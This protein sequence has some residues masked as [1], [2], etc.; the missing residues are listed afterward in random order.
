MAPLPLQKQILYGMG[1]V[2]ITLSDLLIMQWLLVRYL[3][4]DRPHL[5]PAGLMGALLLLSRFI[6]GLSFALVGNWSDHL[7]TRWGRRMPFLRLTIVPFALLFFLMFNPPMDHDHWI[8][9]VYVSIV[10][11]LYFASYGAIVVP[12]LA[13]LP[14]LTTDLRAR[15]NLITWQSIFV[16]VA[17]FMFAATGKLLSHLGW[18]LVMGGAGV[19]STLFFVPVCSFR[20]SPA[21]DRPG[22]EPLSLW[23]S[24]R[25]AL[26][27][28]A[29]VYA[30][31]PMGI[32]W[33]AL[34]GLTALVPF[35]VV[36]CLG[37]SRDDV[38][39]V[40]VLYLLVSLVAYFGVN[41]LTARI[42]KYPVLCASYLF[43]AFVLASFSLVGVVPIGSDFAQTMVILAACGVPVAGFTV[44]AFPLLADVVDH[45]ER[46]TGRRREAIFYG[47]KGVFQKVLIGFSI[48]TF[49]VV[50][51]L[52]STGARQLRDDGWV[53]FSG[54]YTG[55]E[56]PAPAAP[57]PA[58]PQ[59]ARS[60]KIEVRPAG[61]PAPWY[62]KGPGGSLIQ[63][64]GEKVLTDL[65]AG[66]YALEWGEV[67]GWI[68]PPK[69]KVPTPLGLKIMGVVCGLASF[70]AFLVFRKYPLRERGGSVVVVGS[71]GNE[72]ASAEALLVRVDA[73]D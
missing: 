19:L 54:V 50:P 68:A 21:V 34:N 17:T 26:Q 1:G 7:R 3:P 62:L 48:L 49:T 43:G 31:V 12:Y 55:G 67:P 13:L 20:E 53:V 70:A 14:E 66:P 29:F 22:Q 33:F 65:P 64:T 9:A 44:L 24:I 71:A 47:V 42:G 57:Q 45:D 16:L 46:L 37:R 61:L 73:Q 15:V 27:N 32:F 41:R 40:M 63:G 38:T 8:N 5:A 2:T 23:A 6:E 10:I 51:Y 59:P 56:L 60:V 28:R 25:L 30:L 52:G 35:W 72:D 18:A 4:P 58:E 36:V 11:P 69:E 39:T